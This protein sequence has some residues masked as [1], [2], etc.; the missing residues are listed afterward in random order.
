MC[1]L[2]FSLIYQVLNFFCLFT[3][4]RIIPQPI[5]LVFNKLSDTLVFNKHS[6]ALVLNKHSDALVLNKHSD[7]LVFKK[8]R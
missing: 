5:Y 6:D 3:H 2:F 8:T 7:A 4:L 1:I